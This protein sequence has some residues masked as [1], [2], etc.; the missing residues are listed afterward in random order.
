MAMM[1]NT[2]QHNQGIQAYQ[3]S[4]NWEERSSEKSG[5]VEILKRA[6][7]EYLFFIKNRTCK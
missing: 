6:Q 1:G 2:V 3:G 4:D 5:S 7:V